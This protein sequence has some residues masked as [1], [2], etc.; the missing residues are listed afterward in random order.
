MS[1]LLDKVVTRSYHVIVEEDDVIRVL[2]VINKHHKIVP[3]MAVGNCGWVDTKKW[4][5]HF[6]TTLYKW[7]LIR[8]DLKVVRVFK[9]TDIPENTI[10]TVYTT[11]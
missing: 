6:D 11:D 10:G 4:F 1:N 2:N 7:E 9:V 8:N 5:I 3:N